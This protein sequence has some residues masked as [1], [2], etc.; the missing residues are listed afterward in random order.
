MKPGTAMAEPILEILSLKKKYPVYG[1]LHRLLPPVDHVHAVQDV[2]LTLREGETYG[3]VGE[4]GSGK[5]TVGRLIAGLTPA[6]GGSIRYRGKELLGLSKKEWKPYRKDIQF[7][8]QDPFSSLDPRE[9]AG[10]ILEEALI[11]HRMGGPAERRKRVLEILEMTGLQQEHYFRRPHEFSGGQQQR[12]SLARALIINP[13]IIICDEPVS[14]LD[15]SIQSQILNILMALQQKMKLT[16]LFITHD[17]RVVR[18]ISDRVGVMYLGTIVE[19]SPTEDLFSGPR[20]PYTQAL[21]SAVPDS[22]RDSLRDRIILPGEIPSYTDSLRGCV[23]HTRCPRAADLCRTAQPE[24]RQTGPE[25]L[26][27]CHFPL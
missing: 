11:I 15:V 23:F 20:H 19:E 25:H 3:M 22:S 8:F 14:A 18:H 10:E 5:T 24:A 1:R 13:K 9:K 2:S 7:V 17:I 27:R 26:T 6:D 16:L 12:L 4:S 21:F